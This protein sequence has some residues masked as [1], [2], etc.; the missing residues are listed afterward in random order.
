MFNMGRALLN[1]HSVKSKAGEVLKT[2]NRLNA[3]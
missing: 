2:N 3:L 1:H